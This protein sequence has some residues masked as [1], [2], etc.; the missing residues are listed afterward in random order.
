VFHLVT[1]DETDTLYRDLHER[2][3]D[4]LIARKGGRFNDEKLG[5]EILYDPSLVVMA[6]S[7]PRGLAGDASPLRS[8]S[9]NHGCCHRLK[10][11]WDRRIWRSSMPAVSIILA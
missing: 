6:G 10:A 2:N 5:F 8:W 1:S 7:E 4:F 3:V 11:S 9:T